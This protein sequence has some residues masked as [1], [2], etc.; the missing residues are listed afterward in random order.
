MLFFNIRHVLFGVN[1]IVFA[2]NITAE[3][4]PGVFLTRLCSINFPIEEEQY[5]V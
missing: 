4:V 1:G 2:Y 3:I 5:S